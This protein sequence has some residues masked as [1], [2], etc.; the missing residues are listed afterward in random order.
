[1]QIP[2]PILPYHSE[3]S[4]LRQPDQGSLVKIHL[5]STWTNLKEAGANESEFLF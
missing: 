2:W 3:L 5:Y 1:M 4:H